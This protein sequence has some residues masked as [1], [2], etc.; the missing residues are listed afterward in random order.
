MTEE[1]KHVTEW[2]MEATGMTLQVRNG[3][4]AVSGLRLDSI[5]DPGMNGLRLDLYPEPGEDAGQL[6]DR[7]V[8]VLYKLPRST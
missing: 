4:K 6:G 2:E 8:L 3:A 5:Q 7:Y 1:R